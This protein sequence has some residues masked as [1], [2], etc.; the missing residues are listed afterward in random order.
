M[1]SASADATTARNIN[2]RHGR[3][4]SGEKIQSATATT[5]GKKYGTKPKCRPTRKYSTFSEKRFTKSLRTFP[6]SESLVLISMPRPSHA[7]VAPL[8]VEFAAVHGCR[9]VQ[10]GGREGK[11]RSHDDAME[12]A[13][14]PPR[15]QDERRDEEN[16]RRFG[17]RHR[18]EKQGREEVASGA[19]QEAGSFG[20]HFFVRPGNVRD[21]DERKIQNLGREKHS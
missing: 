8:V 20:S 18:A 21:G 11:H 17:I 15:P 14:A 9:A 4:R 7:S 10:G 5:P 12:Q 13:P 3:A 6:A 1:I 19:S 2:S 16:V